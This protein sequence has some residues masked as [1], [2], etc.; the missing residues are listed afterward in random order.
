MATFGRAKGFKLYSRLLLTL[1]AHKSDH[2]CRLMAPNEENKDD[3]FSHQ[4]VNHVP[5]CTAY[6]VFKLKEVIDQLSLRVRRI[7]AM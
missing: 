3:K 2:N 1:C 7:E 4:A 6:D 5:I